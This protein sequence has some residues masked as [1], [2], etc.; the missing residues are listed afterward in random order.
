AFNGG[1]RD[2]V[3]PAVVAGIPH[4][5][6]DA[7]VLLQVP[8]PFAGIERTKV[9][10][11]PVIG[12][13]LGGARGGTGREQ[14]ESPE[15]DGSATNGPDHEAHRGPAS[16]GGDFAAAVASGLTVRCRSRL[17]PEPRTDRRR[18]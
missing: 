12:R 5:G 11:D 16:A 8:L 9:G 7:G 6:G 1:E 14:R 17:P 15:S 2:V 10:R 18:R 4:L 3:E 13:A